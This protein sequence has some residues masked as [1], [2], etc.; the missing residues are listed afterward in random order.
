MNENALVIL[1]G[2]QDST[3]CLFWAKQQFAN[4]FALSFDYGQRHRNELDSAKTVA[5]MADVRHEV[6][7]LGPIFAGLSPLTNAACELDQYAS[8]AHLPGGLEKTFVPGRNILFLTVAAN[9]AYVLGCKNLVIGVSQEDFGGYPDCRE[10]FLEKMSASLTSGLDSRISIYAPLM[11][12]NK[13]QSV[14]LAK[15]LPGCFE[16]LSH[17]T[18]CYAGTVPPCSHCHACLLRS[19]G[20]E[21]AG[22][23][24]P[25]LA[26]IDAAVLDQPAYAR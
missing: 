5:R 9:R 2:G 26:R 10:D 16:A 7:N 20:F 24:D 22:I 8:A 11:R 15:N 13:A 6:I 23:E 19:R 3:T 4:V 1:S 21:E 17:T 12:M 25:M 18:T 14:L